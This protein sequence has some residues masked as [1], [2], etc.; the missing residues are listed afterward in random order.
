MVSVDGQVKR[1]L[2]GVRDTLFL[3]VAAGTLLAAAVVGTV[4]ATL[5]R[6]IAELTRSAR[7]IESGDLDL[8]IDVKS[9]DEI[10]QL[11]E[12]FNA[13]ASRLREFR[14]IDHERLA[15][16]QQ[17]TQLAIDSLPDAVLVIGPGCVVEISNRTAQTHFGIHPGAIVA[18]LK[19]PW[20]SELHEKVLRDRTPMEPQGY[21]S[22]IQLFDDGHER[23]LLPRAVPMFDSQH[24][25]IG[26]T[27]ILVDVTRLR[28][29]DELKSG[30]VSMV[31]HE[32][33]TPLTSI[34]MAVALA[35]SE[36]LGPLTP[37]Q[38]TV[39]TAARDD[40]ER[41]YRIIENLL[42]MSRIED[43]ATQF[44]LRRMTAEEIVVQAVEPLRSAFAEKK[45]SL[46]V[47]VPNDLPA[48]EA[49]PS[50]IG[51]ALSNLLSNAQKYTP[52][53][54][55]VK[56]NVCDADGFLIFAVADNG[57]GIP[58]E[59]VGRIFDKFFRVPKASGP[60]GAGL[61]LSIAKEI[62]EAHGGSIG[63]E[64]SSNGC[65]FWFKSP[66]AIAA[67]QRPAVRDASRRG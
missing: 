7:Q 10:G 58:A 45:I 51:L 5:H 48:V 60:S 8:R 18:D 1:T 67:G 24:Q 65:T 36:K 23:F 25:P 42:S 9:R 59:F 4:A 39:L 66:V 11:S 63:F 50:C 3:L 47:D 52:T 31:S 62:V 43:G 29:A 16:T 46:T 28:A 53:G 13:M 44:Q 40:A 19:L 49:D 30:L 56:L 20:L 33:R 35:I 21:K 15:R 41:L 37:K 57:P 2:I 54:G 55:E 32:L 27:V 61:G 64:N 34:R 14:R 22:A 6:P 17:T 38:K 26:V 12:A